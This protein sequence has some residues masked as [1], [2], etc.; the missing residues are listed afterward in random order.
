M[1]APPRPQTLPPGAPRPNPNP[2]RNVVLSSLPV[3]P[4]VK[5][6]VDLAASLLS[7]TGRR[8]GGGAS[9]QQAQQTAV[10][11]E[12][13]RAMREA[14]MVKALTTALQQVDLDHPQ[15]SWLFQV[16]F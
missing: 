11:A 6:F 16:A 4:Q 15:A 1:H 7:T 14:G 5:A 13:V 9:A 12:I 10:S 2:N 8:G 3:I